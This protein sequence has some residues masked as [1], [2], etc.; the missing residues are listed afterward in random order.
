MKKIVLL[1]GGG[2]NE[3]N[4]SLQSA[5]YVRKSLEQISNIEIIELTLEKNG[6][7]HDGKNNYEFC[8]GGIRI[9]NGTEISIDYLIPII[10]GKP[11][12][13]GELQSILEFYAIN[14]FGNTSGPSITCFNKVSTKLWLDS[15]GIET[16]P[17]IYLA[18]NYDLKDVE[19]FVMATDIFI[20]ASSEGSSV[21]CY[22]INQEDIEDAH[23]KIEMAF[24]YS[25]YVLIEPVVKM[26]ELEVAVWE[27]NGEISVSY[28]GEIKNDG[29]FYDFDSKYNGSS[30][31]KTTVHPENIS[32]EVAE[33][34]QLNA[35]KAWRLLKLRDLARVDFFLTQDDKIYINEINTMPGMTEISLFPQML[36]ESGV[37]FTEFLKTKI[38]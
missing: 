34:I 9:I 10:H 22:K 30:S 5:I 18:E 11:A 24:S 15:A 21:G 1:K 6:Q 20:K 12:E 31:A 17:Y 33:K 4:I 14:Y 29:N 35:L 36:K 16:T 37:D 25:P 28:P 26:R 8:L 23:K 38:L 2:G 13:T 27:M 19:Q 32:D 7:I 3:H